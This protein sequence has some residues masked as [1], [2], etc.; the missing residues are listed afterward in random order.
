MVSKTSDKEIRLNGKQNI[1]LKP[2]KM[3]KKDEGEQQSGGD[4]NKRECLVKKLTKL[5]RKERHKQSPLSYFETN[6]KPKL[7]STPMYEE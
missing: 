6:Y 7:A 4:E 2:C 5:S 3:T 1:S